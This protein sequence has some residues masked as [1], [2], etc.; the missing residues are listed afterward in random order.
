MPGDVSKLH[1]LP[2]SLKRPLEIDI[3]L[4][5]WNTVDSCRKKIVRRTFGNII[6]TYKLI[7]FWFSRMVS[8]LQ[9]VNFKKPGRSFF[10]FVVNR[11]GLSRTP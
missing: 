6:E 2:V 5:V 3:I 8:G 4:G 9:W 10:I 11:N 7:G 1:V